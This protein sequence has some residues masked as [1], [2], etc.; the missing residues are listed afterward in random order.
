M[1]PMVKNGK[2]W[3]VIS[4]ECP[5]D[6]AGIRRVNLAAFDGPVEASLVE[7]LRQ[8]CPNCVSLVAKLEDQVVGHI[9]FTPVRIEISG[10]DCIEGMGLGPMAVL[11]EYQRR[12]VGS[13]LCEAGLK[14]IEQRGEPFVVVLGHPSYYPRFCFMPASA[15][16]VICVYQD[17]PNDAFMIRVFNPDAMKGVQGVAYYRKE[18]DQVS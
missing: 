15:F 17:V 7:Q 1:V 5:D 13:A 16:G 8:T 11:P 3:F 2:T 10:G 18:F 14:I 4:H 9:L 12:G 6:I